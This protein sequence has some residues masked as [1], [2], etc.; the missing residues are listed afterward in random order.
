MNQA[1]FVKW[2][3]KNGLYRLRPYTSIQ[4]ETLSVDAGRAVHTF[5]ARHVGG[6][7]RARYTEEIPYEAAWETGP[8]TRIQSLIKRR[9]I[10]VDHKTGFFQDYEMDTARDFQKQSRQ[11]AVQG[12]SAVLPHGV[13]RELVSR[14]LW[15]CDKYM[16]SGWQRDAM[17][18]YIR[19]QVNAHLRRG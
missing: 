6:V 16:K 12:G 18:N 14:I 17:M 11:N 19:T 13:T 4:I 7:A 2:T 5:G 8:V 1:D 3:V 9:D 15:Y 10:L